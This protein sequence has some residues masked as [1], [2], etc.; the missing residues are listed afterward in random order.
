[1]SVTKCM[2]IL[3]CLCY[4]LCVYYT[5]QPHGRQRGD[6]IVGDVEDSEMCEFGD[7]SADL[8]KLIVGQVEPL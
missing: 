5:G 7:V 6:L 3:V 2:C 4:N 8:G 1:M